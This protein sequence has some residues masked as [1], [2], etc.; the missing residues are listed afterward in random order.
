MFS[1]SKEEEAVKRAIRRGVGDFRFINILQL[2]SIRN[3]RFHLFISSITL[4]YHL[5]LYFFAPT[6]FTHTHYPY[7]LKTTFSYTPPNVV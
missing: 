5:F 1:Q 4:F 2:L 3:S 6:T 7:P